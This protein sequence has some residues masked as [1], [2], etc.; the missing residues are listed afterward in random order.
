MSHEALAF[1]SREDFS[2]VAMLTN[3]EYR[4]LLERPDMSDKEVNALRAGLQAF[5]GQFLDEYFQE[6][7]DRSD[8]DDRGLLK[9]TPPSGRVVACSRLPARYSRKVQ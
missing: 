3:D 6:A 7:L 9:R 4:V 5:L 8:L 1:R 2:L